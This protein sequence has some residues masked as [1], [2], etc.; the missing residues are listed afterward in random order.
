MCKSLCP[1]SSLTNSYYSCYT[2][3]ALDQFLEHLIECG[4]EKVLRIGGQSHS[5][6]LKGKNLR[7]VSQSESKTKSERYLLAKTYEAL[8]NQEKTIK[9]LL[10]SMHAL[11]KRPEWTSLKSYLLNR[12]DSIYAQFSRDDDD[13][14]T[15][16][17]KEPFDAWMDGTLPSREEQLG[18]TDSLSDSIEQVMLVATRNVYCISLHNRHRLVRFRAEEANKETVDEIFELVKDANNLHKELTNVHDDVD[19]R[20]LQTAD[21]IGVTTTGLAKRIASLRHVKCKVVVCEE[22][23][24]VME[25]HIISALLPSVEHFIQIGDHQQLRPQINNFNLSLESPQG[26]L[27]KL[28]RSQFER[29]SIGQPGTPSF[30][31]AQLN[32]QRRMRPE[33]STLIRETM[34]PR[35]VDHETTKKLPDVVGMRKNVFLLDHNNI[36]DG[37]E[38]DTY[39]RSH[40]NEWEVEMTHALV[41]HIVRQGIYS[42]NDI[43]VL[44]P[45]MG[46]LQKL[47]TKMR[48][49]FEIVISDRDQ[50]T[51]VK[52]MFG[53]EDILSGDD[54]TS[55]HL[56]L[57]KR[58]L[59]KKKLSELL[60]VATVD[61]FQGEEAKIIIVSLVRSNKEKRVGF[62]RT[63]NRINVL[64]SRAQHGLYL[65][66][67]IDTY[68][69]QPMW[70]Q[71]H[72][73]LDATGSVG[74]AFGLCC[75]RHINTVIQVFQPDDF[76][77]L[78]PEGGCQLTCDRRLTECGHRCQARCHSE[79]MHLVFACPQPCQRLHSPCNHVCQKQT[80]GESCGPCMFILDNVQLPC[81]HLKDN[82]PC[83][84]TQDLGKIQCNVPCQKKISSCQHIVEIP[85][86]QDITS[87]QFSCPAGC[88][89]TLICGHQC[90]GTCGRCNQ[91]VVKHA[92]C[93][94]VC[95]R[96]FG[97]C[98]HTCPRM[99]HDGKEC[100][101]CLSPCEVSFYFIAQERAWSF[102][103][104]RPL[105]LTFGEQY[106]VRLPP[107]V[108]YHCC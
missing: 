95:G 54:R 30:P 33:I 81:N 41:R 79:S 86:S 31:V 23:G 20:V 25:P 63:H 52:Q 66:G 103:L 9:K 11:Q 58:P 92:S 28:D 2:N 34:Y 26:A 45:Y 35:L 16:V 13:G 102:V 40:S 19:R 76:A 80:C 48:N 37:V 17:G 57:G 50:E 49:D 64:L 94:K 56:E 69:N 105:Y 90:P 12:Y 77:R 70:A 62:L 87:K 91:S 29:L 32:I 42:S 53:V 60:R 46:Q 75:P 65:I 99:C 74:P 55:G 100:S 8:E 5:A 97:T 67:N 15:M 1:V 107:V 39:Q 14:F 83:Y 73:M 96:R 84:L 88:A 85:C 68:S 21:V 59:E 82:V 108:S 47:R 61:N 72:S 101:P 44:T 36:E 7:I 27:Y 38:A 6:I 71:I 43:A 3:H 89:F 98:S 78:S 22:A 24:E 10:G 104:Y 51:L 4:I 93:A 18:N 106:L